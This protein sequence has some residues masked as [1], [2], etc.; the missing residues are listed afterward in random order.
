MRRVLD[1]GCGRGDFPVRANLSFDDEVVGVDID[2]ERLAVARARF[3][4]RVFRC[5]KG[6]ALLFPTHHSIASSLLW[7][8][9]TWIFPRLWRK[10]GGFWLTAEAYF[11][12]CTLCDSRCANFGHPCLT[13]SP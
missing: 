3:P 6:E 13:P 7:P 5:A 12:A 8:F 4:Q 11:S 2:E 10:Y 9:P 1:L